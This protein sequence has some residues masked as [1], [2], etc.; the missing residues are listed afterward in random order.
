MRGAQNR[1]VSLDVKGD[2]IRSLALDHQ[3]TVVSDR[4]ES[5]PDP[6]PVQPERQL[7]AGNRPFVEVSLFQKPKPFP[8]PPEDPWEFRNGQ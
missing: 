8:E 5:G 3:L 2:S 7:R 1:P 6:Q 4:F